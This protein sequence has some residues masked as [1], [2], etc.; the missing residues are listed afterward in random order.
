MTFSIIAADLEHGE[1]GVAVASR[2]LA[3]GAMVPRAAAEIGVVV[4][5]SAFGPPAAPDVL[6]ALGEHASAEAALRR[7]L[8]ADEKA[9][10]HGQLGVVD[11]AGC[12]AAHTGPDCTPWKGHR[13]GDGFSAQGNFLVGP[14]VVERLASEFE[15]ARRSM[16]LARALLHSLRAGDAAGGDA[17]GRQSAALLVVRAG[18]GFQDRG[19]RYIDLRADDHSSPID[20]LCRLLAVHQLWRGSRQNEPMELD[21]PELR[22]DLGLLLRM[23]AGAALQAPEGDTWEQWRAFCRQ[24]GWSDADVTADRLN[25]LKRAAFARQLAL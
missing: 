17:R 2:T 25:R 12:A 7:V 4:G 18:S 19:D 15:Q 9:M 14:Q 24:Q 21:R 16:S 20:E 10:Q 22:R 1:W 23:A 13:V 11:G 3:V 5:Q 8:A 6:A